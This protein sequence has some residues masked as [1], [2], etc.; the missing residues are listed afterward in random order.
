MLLAKSK[1][2]SI[3]AGIS[4]ALIGSNIEWMILF[5]KCCAERSLWYEERN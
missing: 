1:F 5:N 3:E 2:N 4:K